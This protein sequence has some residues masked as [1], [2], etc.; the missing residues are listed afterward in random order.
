[1]PSNKDLDK[2]DTKQFIKIPFKPSSLETID[3]AVF[4]FVNE[5]MNIHARTN[6]G[7]KK[8]PVIWAGRER[9]FINK[10]DPEL[11]NQQTKRFKLPVVTIRRTGKEKNTASKGVIYGNIPDQTDEKGGVASFTISREINQDKTSKFANAD[12]F[13]KVG[14]INFP[15]KNQKVVYETVTIPHPVYLQVNYEIKLEA[16][17]QEQMNQMAQ[18][19]IVETGT[20]N[21]FFV[22]HDGHRFEAFFED[23][24]TE[25]N[26][27]EDF[28]D[29]PRT[30]MT[31]VSIKVYGYLISAGP[32]DE[33][34]FIIRRQN[35]V[36][37]K[38]PRERVIVGDVN[39]FDEDGFFR[40]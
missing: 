11:R 35:A 34:P 27:S 19:F 13:K 12:A 16:E 14:K 6:E 36:E 40:P 9:A 24:Y 18:P 22:K 8:V 29:E 5:Q 23:S 28:S 4:N 10:D 32:N 20:T 31:T 3:T 25:D 2:V 17:Y 1:M 30:F 38:I 21:D 33:Q 26:N 15:R 7:F 37:V 39:D